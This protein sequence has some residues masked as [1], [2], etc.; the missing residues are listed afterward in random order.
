MRILGMTLSVGL[1]EPIYGSLCL[2]HCDR[3]EKLSEDFHFQ[4]LPPQWEGEST[5]AEDRAIFSLESPSPAV[6]LLVQLEKPATEEA[7]SGIKSNV[8]SRKDPVSPPLPHVQ[9]RL[10]AP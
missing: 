10:S 7:S 3:K 2:Y 4:F 1:V 5:T 6:C 8:Y 9:P